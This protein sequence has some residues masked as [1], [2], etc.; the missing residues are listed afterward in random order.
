MHR[1]LL[2]ETVSLKGG[3]FFPFSS[4][5]ISPFL[6]PYPGLRLLHF[7]IAVCIPSYKRVLKLRLPL[8]TSGFPSANMGILIRPSTLSAVLLLFLLFSASLPRLSLGRLHA[9]G[10]TGE[11]Y[12]IDYRGPETHSSSL[13]PP[14]RPHQ[15][16]SSP[17]P[18]IHGK[19][20][21]SRKV[22]G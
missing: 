17:S 20:L 15:H 19:S 5:P 7:R 2:M 14:N 11:V 21:Q 3:F 16:G 13:P 18:L 4:L 1:Q 8:T 12:Q 6:L 9:E 10:E 22:H